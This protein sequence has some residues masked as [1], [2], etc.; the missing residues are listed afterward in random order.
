[1]RNE[2]SV[3]MIARMRESAEITRSS[4]D[5]KLP[6]PPLLSWLAHP[7]LLHNLRTTATTIH[8]HVH[9]IIS[10]DQGK[11]LQFL[12]ELGPLKHVQQKGGKVEGMYLI[13]YFRMILASHSL[14]NNNLQED[15]KARRKN[16]VATY[17]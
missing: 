10:L 11:N 15:I 2:S 7:S 9:V 4:E 3:E 8:K 16:Q 5:K 17:F 12:D 13:G 1:M 14:S 6:L